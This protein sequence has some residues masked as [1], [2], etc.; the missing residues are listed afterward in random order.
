[1]FSSVLDK[2]GDH[3]RH[4]ELEDLGD[5]RKAAHTIRKRALA[6]GSSN[7]LNPRVRLCR[8]KTSERLAKSQR[9]DNVEREEV[10]PQNNV[11]ALLAWSELA[12]LA[13]EEI[14]H[15]ADQAFL[16][17]QAPVGKC[18][19]QVL[20]HDTMLYRITLTHDGVGGVG[21]A[22]AIVEWAF[23]ECLVV[24]PKAINVTP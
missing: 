15:F 7:E 20:P 16:L 23:D 6:H 1:M 3:P 19:T 21:E 9:S 12:D 5:K 11:N 18:M 22:A 10:E 8:A 14:D 13:D 2:L 17:P 4:Q 24:R